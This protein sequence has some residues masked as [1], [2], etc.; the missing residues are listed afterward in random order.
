MR[1]R[2]LLSLESAIHKM[3]GLPADVLGMRDRGRIVPGAVADLVLF[4]PATIVDEATYEAPTRLSRGIEWVF[5]GGRP[6]M[7]R[8]EIV[9]R[10]LGSVIRRGGQ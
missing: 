7:E 1:E 10:D 5:L 2:G 9:A 8:G 3:T 6:A 4:D